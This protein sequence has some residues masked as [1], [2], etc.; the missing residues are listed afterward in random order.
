MGTLIDPLAA[1]CEALAGASAPPMPW[2]APYRACGLG[3]ARHVAAGRPVAQALNTALQAEPVSMPGQRVLRF[4]PQS[5]L[6]DG[7]AYEAFIART[8]SVPTRDNL[9]DLFNGLVWLRFAPL[10]RQLNLLQARQIAQA[11]ITATRGPLRDALTLFDESAALLHAPAVLVQALQQRDWRALFTTHRAAWQAA[12]LT[13]FGHA[14]LEKLMQPRKPITAHVWLL[15]DAQALAPVAPGA[16]P[17]GWPGPGWFADNPHLPL[18]VLGVPGWWAANEEA[19]FYA[20]ASVFRPAPP[21]PGT[22]KQR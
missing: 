10:K 1:V 19:H 11:G 14:L 15:P 5:E 13:L 3:V 12:R 4:V 2:L 17:V 6:P 9:H 8:A 7:E 22:A 21:Q 18:P 16:L 20:D